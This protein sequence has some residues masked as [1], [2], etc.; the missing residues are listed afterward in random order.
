MHKKQA[1][2]AFIAGLSVILLW[3]ASKSEAQPRP[4]WQFPLTPAPN[5]ARAFDQPI[6]NWLPGH[7]GVDLRARSGQLVVAPENGVITFA[8]DI[9]GRGVVVIKH[10]QLRS[11]YEPIDSQLAI[12]DQVRRGDKIGRL[13]CGDNHCCV[14][15]RVMCL[16]WGLLRGRQYLNPL[17]KVDIHI[18]LLP[19]EPLLPRLPITKNSEPESAGSEKRPVG[20]VAKDST[21]HADVPARKPNVND[22][23]KHAYKVAWLPNWHVQGFLALL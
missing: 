14:G 17:S 8:S 4:Y 1:L 20:S 12:G 21:M 19:I 5:I 10:G 2:A 23:L 16:H 6:H 18:R 15:T 11:T 7:R 22:P 13:K 3:L 9:A